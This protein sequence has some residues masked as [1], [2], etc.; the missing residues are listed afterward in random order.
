MSAVKS[1]QC[2]APVLLTA[3]GMRSLIAL[4]SSAGLLLAFS[5]ASARGSILL[6]ALFGAPLPEQCVQLSLVALECEGS[7]VVLTEGGPELHLELPC[8]K[9]LGGCAPSRALLQG[10]QSCS[11]L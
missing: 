9:R 1:N 4:K 6:F 7:F 5:S 10:R 8:L 2:V 3:E 11:A